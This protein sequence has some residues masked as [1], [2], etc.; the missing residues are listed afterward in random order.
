[1]FDF[2]EKNEGW[3]KGEN[4]YFTLCSAAICLPP[5]WRGRLILR[6]PPLQGYKKG[7][8]RIKRG[9]K[10]GKIKNNSPFSFVVSPYCERTWGNAE[11]KIAESLFTSQPINL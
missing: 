8:K 11:K 3:G 9:V 6:Q 7:E 5:L 10:R 2:P 4:P 1:M